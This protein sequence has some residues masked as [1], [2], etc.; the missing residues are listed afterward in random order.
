M[1]GDGSLADVK[2]MGTAACFSGIERPE[3]VSSLGFV[4]SLYW[5]PTGPNSVVAH[6]TNDHDSSVECNRTNNNNNN[7]K[8]ITTTTRTP[9]PNGHVLLWS[10]K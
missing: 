9:R 8:T 7:N 6:D 3:Y 10:E 4:A 1:V 5:E 2:Q